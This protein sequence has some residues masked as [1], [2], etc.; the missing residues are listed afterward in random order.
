MKCQAYTCAIDGMR[1]RVYD[2]MS[3]QIQFSISPSGGR[4]PVQAT[5]SGTLCTILYEPDRTSGIVGGLYNCDNGGQI[6][7]PLCR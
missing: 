5:I 7:R 1:V 3:G 2:A 4:R 6:M